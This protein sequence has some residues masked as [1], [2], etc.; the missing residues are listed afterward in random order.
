M[1]F[2]TGL[3][4]FLLV[5]IVEGKDTVPQHVF[6]DIYKLGRGTVTNSAR[7]LEQLGV[8]ER[9]RCWSDY[10]NDMVLCYKLT[11]KGKKLLECLKRMYEI[12][13]LRPALPVNG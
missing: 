4:K 2:G 3:E 11:D 10:K 9:S 8:I 5:F 1:L 13:G 6:Y 7:Y 12:V